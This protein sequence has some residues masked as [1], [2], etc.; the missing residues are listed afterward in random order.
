MS[1]IRGASILPE[2]Q[3]NAGITDGLTPPYIA[4]LD[5][6]HV[7]TF[8][9]GGLQQKADG[10]PCFATK[11]ATFT[12]LVVAKTSDDAETLAAQVEA[13]VDLNTGLTTNCIGCF[14]ENFRSSQMQEKLY[15][16]GVEIEYKL[17]ESYD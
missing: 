14:Q 2:K 17:T 11:D 12:V 15:Q 10:K 8:D 16:W 4:V 13:F 1:S 5:Y 3:V 6:E 9:T 7:P